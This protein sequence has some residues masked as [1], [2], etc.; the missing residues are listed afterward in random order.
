M[1]LA[2]GQKEG[3]HFE[4]EGNRIILLLRLLSPLS[5]DYRLHL[6]LIY[7]YVYFPVFVE[8]LTGFKWIGSCALSLQSQG[9]QG[10]A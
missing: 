1:L 2:M 6:A 10:E 9:Y 4:G 8:T 3:F 5:V 7:L